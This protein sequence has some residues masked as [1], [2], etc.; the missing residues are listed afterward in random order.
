MENPLISIIAV[1][2]FAGDF[3]KLLEESV[4]RHTHGAYE[5]III[6]NSNSE[7]SPGSYLQTITPNENLGHGK[8]LNLGLHEA[9]GKYVCVMDIDSHILM[10]G[11]DK[12]MISLFENN[13]KLRLVA[14]DGG[15]LKPVRPLFMFFERDIFLYH[16][17]D[18]KA[19][20]FDGVKFD[21]GIH[22]YFKILTLFGERSVRKLSCEKTAYNDVLG[23]EYA[24]NGERVVYHNWYG[25][26]WYN[27]EGK[28]VHDQIDRVKW[29][30]FKKK[31][32]NLFLQ[33]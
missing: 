4:K 21:V 33:I 18:F 20:N 11:W 25:T 8:G 12:K 17:I 2:W 26:R 30:D 24:L 29:D 32:D 23:N 27:P 14:A 1:N 13:D 15:L 3:A 19:K 9:G 5:L 6:N 22:A 31:K 28:R 7:I 16:N 10:P